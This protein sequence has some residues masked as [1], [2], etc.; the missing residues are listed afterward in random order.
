MRADPLHLVDVGQDE[1]ASASPSQ[2]SR[3]DRE[4]HGEEKMLVKNVSTRLREKG[5]KESVGSR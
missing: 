5:Y 2:L 1:K 3:Y 4:P